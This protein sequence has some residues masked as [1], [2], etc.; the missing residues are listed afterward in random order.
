MLFLTLE[1]LEGSLDVMILPDLYRRIKNMVYDTAPF[2]VSGVLEY[3]EV[4]GE[5]LLRADSFR[6]LK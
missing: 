4:R 1:D 5:P 6:Q 2:I 3:D